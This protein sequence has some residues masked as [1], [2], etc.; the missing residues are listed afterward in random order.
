[1][2]CLYLSSR[3]AALMDCERSSD[4]ISTP[5]ASAVS[6]TTVK[7][8]RGKAGRL[9][10]R[11]AGVRLQPRMTPQVIESGFRQ[12]REKD[13]VQYATNLFSL[14]TD[15]RT[16]RVGAN[17]PQA[18]DAQGGARLRDRRRLLPRQLHAAHGLVAEAGHGIRPHETGRDR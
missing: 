18:D 14:H 7:R 1:M 8:S 11:K 12:E 15:D 2:F 4:V 6:E 16:C 13:E 3:S 17:R 5:S 10:L 9:F